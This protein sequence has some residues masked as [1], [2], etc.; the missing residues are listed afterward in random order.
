MREDLMELNRSFPEDKI[1]NKYEN[2]PAPQTIRKVNRSKE[3]LLHMYHMTRKI[4]A[5]WYDIYKTNFENN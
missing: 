4:Q 1:T 2:H 3:Q 5:A